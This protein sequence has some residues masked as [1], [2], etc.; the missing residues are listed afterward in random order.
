MPRLRVDD[1]E[2]DVDELEEAEYEESSYEPYK[3]KQ[4]PKGTVLYGYLKKV[5]WTYNSNDVRMLTV[6]FEAT[7]ESGKY[8][9]LGVWDRLTLNPASKFRWAPF[10]E[11]TGITLSDI[12][13]KMIVEKQDE[14]QGRPVKKIGTFVVG[15]EEKSAVRIITGRELFR[16]E[17]QT[18]A[19]KWLPWA[20][21]DDDDEEEEEEE[22]ED[23]LEDDEEEEEEAPPPPRRRAAAAK[24]AT[25]SKGGAARRRPARQPEPEEDDEDE[26]EDYE[27]EEDEDEPPARPARKAS[28]RPAGRATAARPA[29]PVARAPRSGSATPARSGRVAKATV[30]G[31]RSSAGYDDEPPF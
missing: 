20:D 21:P 3:G 10:L 16:E 2:L 31:R 11:A 4:P 14:N 1:D 22:F 19:D 8:K 24:S 5:W 9:G 26:L 25:P 18:K 13:N 15:D 7:A 28:A 30:K 17:W 29:R 23:D 27:D 6:I 12:K